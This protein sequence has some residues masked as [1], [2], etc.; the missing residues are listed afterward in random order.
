MSHGI[1]T[2]VF[3]EINVN[4]VVVRSRWSVVTGNDFRGEGGDRNFSPFPFPKMEF[5]TSTRYPM[6]KKVFKWKIE[7]IW[8]LYQ[9]VDNDSAF[10]KANFQTNFGDFQLNLIRSM[11]VKM[12]TCSVP[13]NSSNNSNNNNRHRYRRFNVT[14]TTTCLRLEMNNFKS[15]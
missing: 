3:I 1:R 14:S 9:S 12:E 15:M 6:A 2:V 4:K 7:D 10:F 13:H 11:T 8:S 5:S